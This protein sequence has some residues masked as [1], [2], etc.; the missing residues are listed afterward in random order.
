MVAPILK[1]PGAKW[2]LANWIIGY[3]PD[4]KVYCEPYFGSGAIY[5]NKKPAV[6]E[7]INDIDQNVVNLFR[8]I[9]DH[10]EELARLIDFTPWSRTEY[11]Q[12]KNSVRNGGSYI[13]L[14][15][16]SIEDA[17]RFLVRCWQ[18]HSIKTSDVT[19]WSYRKNEIGAHH[20]RTWRDI[21][22]RILVIA[23]RLKMAQI[24]CL[25]AADVIRR[26]MSPEVLIY[27]D[28]PYP[29]DTKSQR[30]YAN[31]MSDDEHIEMLDLLDAHTGPVVLS[32]YANELYDDR[33]QHWSR[34]TR[35]TQADSGKSRTEVLWLNPVCVERLQ[36]PLFE[37]SD[38]IAGI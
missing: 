22:D 36:M 38:D 16:D 24:E 19:G 8:V 12:S 6:I 25:P 29:R 9:R 11:R 37:R 21:P 1:Y 3:L 4:H 30:L 34:Q 28:P 23:Q 7:T 33:L 27:A 31:E 10:P 18:A 5:F 17:R 20:T 35:L 13:N 14:S 15:G 26:H 32:G 2:R